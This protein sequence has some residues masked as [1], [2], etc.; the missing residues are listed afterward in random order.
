MVAGKESV[1]WPALV[2]EPDAHD[3]LEPRSCAP[4]VE[5]NLLVAIQQ[6]A[7]P[8]AAGVELFH[9]RGGV[10][11]LGITLGN[12]LAHQR[13]DQ[14]PATEN[15]QAQHCQSQAHAQ[16]KGPAAARHEALHPCLCFHR[17]L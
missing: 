6:L 10:E 2:E 1:N 9:Q 12:L 16:R 13:P 3:A 4:R 5:S 8:A 14:E 17:G 11:R 15:G 7:F